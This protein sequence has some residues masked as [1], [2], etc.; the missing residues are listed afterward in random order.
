MW[1]GST[2]LVPGTGEGMMTLCWKAKMELELMSVSRMAGGMNV[3]VQPLHRQMEE[4][5]GSCCSDWDEDAGDLL[6]FSP[7]GF[8][9][10]SLSSC[11][12]K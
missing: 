6:L 12:K 8:G 9:S 4:G 5:D 3:L 10:T 1:G 11:W 2:V 7:T